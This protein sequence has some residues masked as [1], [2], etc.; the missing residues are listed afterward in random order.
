M[1]EQQQQARSYRVAAGHLRLAAWD[2][3]EDALRAHVTRF[4]KDLAAV[5]SLA[6]VLER[7]A[8]LDE[9][10]AMTRRSERLLQELK[11]TL[12]ERPQRS[13]RKEAFERLEAAAK[14]APDDAPLQWMLAE[15]FRAAD[16]DEA[17][18]AAYRRFLMK[19]PADPRAPHLLAV[20]G[21]APPPRQAPVPFV[22]AVFDAAAEGDYDA[23]R[24]AVDDRSAEHVAEALQVALAAEPPASAERGLR[25]ADLGCGTG[26][27]G[28]RLRPFVARLDGVDVSPRMAFRARKRGL[29]DHVETAELVTWMRLAKDRY[30]ALAAADV[31]TW[32]GPLRDP[33]SVC[34]RTLEPGGYLAFTAEKGASGPVLLSDGGFAH[35]PAHITEA[36]EAA[37]FEVLLLEDVPLR[38]DG[39]AEVI[40]LRALLRRPGKG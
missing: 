10:A 35:G 29:F 27:C 1:D 8:A 2:A 40:G 4:P 3:A 30:G 13:A 7:R 37:G 17:A 33:L 31:F 23:A 15:A 39:D 14:S 21:G 22:R 16:E 38:R 36:A 26:A 9:A 25:A 34:Y 11:A 19:R 32:F 5:R 28:A 24:A 12:L 20:V 18:A 6:T